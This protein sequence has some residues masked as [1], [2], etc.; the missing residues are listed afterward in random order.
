MLKIDGWRSEL[1][2]TLANIQLPENSVLLTNSIFWLI[3][4]SLLP[5]LH[6]DVPIIFVTLYICYGLEG[7][8]PLKLTGE[9]MPG[10]SEGNEWVVRL[11]TQ[12]VH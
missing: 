11:L 1:S 9:T 12:S 3:F 8:V 7:G 2:P 4:K 5:A 10:D 6:S